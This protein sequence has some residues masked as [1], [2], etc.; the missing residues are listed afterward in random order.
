MNNLIIR[1]LINIFNWTPCVF[2]GSLAWAQLLWGAVEWGLLVSTYVSAV[3]PRGHL[4]P[5]RTVLWTVAS[6]LERLPLSV[7]QKERA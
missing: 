4:Q 7:R 2:L 5:P 3:Y 6:Y 1:Y